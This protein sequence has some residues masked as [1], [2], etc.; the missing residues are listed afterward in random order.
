M[1]VNNSNSES[2]NK[3]EYKDVLQEEIQN[4]LEIESAQSYEEVERK[5]I[6]RFKRTPLEIINRL[7][8]FLFIGSFIFSFI[9]VYSENKTWFIFYVISAFS[10]VFYTPNRKALK[11]LIAAWPNIEDIIRGRSLWR[12]K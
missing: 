8:F 6:S 10:C 9:S 2:L 4:F 1:E 7:L 12:K 11:E 5:K 3:V